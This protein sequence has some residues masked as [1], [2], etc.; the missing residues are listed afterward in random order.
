MKVQ[1]DVELSVVIQESLTQDE[2]LSAHPID[3]LVVD[4]VATLTGSV[5]SYRRKL[6]ALEIAESIQGCRGVTDKLVVTPPG[7]LSDE[8]IADA[9]RAILD[10]HADIT[11]EVITVTVRDSVA[12]LRGNVCTHWEV[13]LAEDLAL[14][15]RGVREVHNHLAVEPSLETE[16]EQLSRSIERALLHTSGMQDT[17]VRVAVTGITATL[18]GQVKELW[19]KKRAEQV[20]R[21]FPVV[22]I[23]NDISLK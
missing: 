20:A 12:T 10:A 6:V 18:S 13:V 16:D 3:V 1:T 14:S 23:N 21:R 9:V 17:E 4:G 5:Q 19:Q 11:K 8:E 7:Q 2:R 15:S 22:V